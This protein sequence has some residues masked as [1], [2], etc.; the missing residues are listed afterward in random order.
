MKRAV[1]GRRR[2]TAAARRDM[3]SR[4]AG[5]VGRCDRLVQRPCVVNGA[6]RSLAARLAV[7]E[8][9]AEAAAVTAILVRVLSA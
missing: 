2:S 5:A 3:R 1:L 4:S 8:K 6:V 9:R 7:A